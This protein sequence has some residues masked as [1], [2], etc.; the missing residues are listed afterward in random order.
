MS[1]QIYILIVGLQQNLVVGS[2]L[3]YLILPLAY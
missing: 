3:K 1:L 2:S